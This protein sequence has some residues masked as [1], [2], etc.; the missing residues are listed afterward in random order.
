MQF[1]DTLVIE[2]LYVPLQGSWVIKQQTI[3]PSVKF[4]GFDAYGSFVQLYDQYDLNPAFPKKF[5]NS[6]IL[7]FADSSNKKPPAYWDSV[8]PV[9]LIAL[10]INDYRK[11]TALSSFERIPGI[12]THWTECVTRLNFLNCYL[13]EKP[14][15]KKKTM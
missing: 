11:K 7:Q 2:Q 12:S 15:A 1:A 10:E 5:F 4:L 14:L 3:Y 9:P 6:T 13:P 8:R